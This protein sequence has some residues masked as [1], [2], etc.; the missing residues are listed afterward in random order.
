MQL[1]MKAFA[2]SHEE[3]AAWYEGAPNAVFCRQRS[4]VRRHVHVYMAISKH[5]HNF[6]VYLE[7]LLCVCEMYI[8]SISTEPNFDI[9]P[10]NSLREG[11]HIYVMP[12]NVTHIIMHIIF[13]FNDC[14]QFLRSLAC[15]IYG[16][17]F[18]PQSLWKKYLGENIESH[19]ECNG[20]NLRETNQSVRISTRAP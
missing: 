17:N 8:A 4:F 7:G 10:L 3:N 9:F 13:I 6:L 12:T 14:Y 11:A 16:R 19:P 18:P 20:P 5:N 1:C 15:P 2:I